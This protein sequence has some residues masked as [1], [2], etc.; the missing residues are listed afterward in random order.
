VR[1]DLAVNGKNRFTVFL[2]KR[3]GGVPDKTGGTVYNQTMFTM[4]PCAAGCGRTAVTGSRLCAVHLTNPEEETNRI[5][6]S[7]AGMNT[8]KD[9]CATELHFE[10]V[11]FGDRRFYGC[12]FTG[13]S[14]T[15]CLFSKSVMRISFFD[16]AVFNDCDFSGSDLQFLSFGGAV[17]R[18]CTFENSELVHINYGGAAITDSTFNNSNLYNSR[19][20]NA[21]IVHTDF[22]DCN[23]KRTS[24]I[25][26]R[27]EGV[28]FKS[29]NTAEA[30]FELGE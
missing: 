5:V 13:A 15:M 8:I 19:F 18:N 7:I 2:R 22:I 14:F 11:N 23:L 12:N 27:Q 16:F 25:K 6:L 3:S 30:V 29:S 9:L 10:G 4:V 26:T 20:I 17:I 1:E 28:S 21:D 24:F